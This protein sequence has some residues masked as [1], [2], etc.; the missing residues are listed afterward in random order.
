MSQILK[1]EIRKDSRYSAPI[2]HVKARNVQAWIEGGY[3]VSPPNE[4]VRVPRYSEIIFE[5]TTDRVISAT[6]A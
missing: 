4:T 3:L 6:L 5:Q 1:Y 2:R